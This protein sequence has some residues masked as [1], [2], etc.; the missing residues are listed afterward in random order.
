MSTRKEFST[1]DQQ[2]KI[3]TNTPSR[4]STSASSNV[5]IDGLLLTYDK[6]LHWICRYYVLDEYDLICFPSK[7]TCRPLKPG[8]ADADECPPLWVSD[9]TNAQVSEEL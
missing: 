2:D 9:V 7:K 5:I 6:Y 1:L 8:A 4:S 3:S